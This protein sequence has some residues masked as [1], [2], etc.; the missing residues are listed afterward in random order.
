[1]ATVKQILREKGS[2]VYSVSPETPI[3]NA[4]ILMADKNIGTVMVM[5]NEKVK[6]IFSER[7][8]V[9]YIAKEGCTA[10]S[11]VDLV[12]THAVYYV[13]PAESVEACM[14][15]MTDKRI[16]HLPVVDDGKVV[17][18][19]SIGDVVKAVMSNYKSL[20]EGLENYIMGGEIKL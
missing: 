1:M 6:G 7:D 2:Q 15:Q 17:G 10:E 9:R 18:I 13:S 4:L 12:M 16:R 14:A 8:Y 5:E 19:I 11:P 3:K 20:I